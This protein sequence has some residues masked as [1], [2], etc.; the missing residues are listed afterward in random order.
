MIMGSPARVVRELSTEEIDNIVRTA[1]HYVQL[2]D[3]YR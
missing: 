1:A 3:S 2:K